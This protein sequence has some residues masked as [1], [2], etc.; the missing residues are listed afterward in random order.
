MF[1]LAR[2]R[3]QGAGVMTVIGLNLS[4]YAATVTRTIGLFSLVK[5]Q[6]V[7]FMAPKYATGQKAASPFAYL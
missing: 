3:R 7:Q 6:A 2:F 1:S 5:V 4:C